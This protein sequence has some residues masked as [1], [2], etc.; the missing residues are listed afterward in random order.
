METIKIPFTGINR[1][2]DEGISTDGQCMEL[3]NAR[4]KN[5]S[6]E[7]IGNPI[8]IHELFDAKKIFYHTIAK[9]TLILLTDGRIQ[10]LNEDYTHCEWLSSDLTGKVND[11]AFIGNIACC[12]T[13]TQIQYEIFENEGYRHIGF[14]P[15]IPEIKIAQTT[16][17]ESICPDIKFLG[18]RKSSP[19]TDEEFM[20]TADYCA[21][22]YY[23][24]CIDTLNKKEYIIGP[25]LLKYAFRNSSGEYTKESPIFLVEH[26]NKIDYTFKFRG[27]TSTDYKEVVSFCQMLPYTCRDNE[28]ANATFKDYTYEFG[29]M[30]T[31][32]GFSFDDFDLSYLS[33]LV[34][35]IDVFI[36]P[37]DWFEKEEKK[38]G[39]VTYS[40]YERTQ[41]EEEQILKAYRFYKVA[42]YS[43]KGEEVW[44]LQDWSKDNISLQEQLI[45]SEIKHSFSAQ[46]NY[47]YNSRLHLANIN[48]SF[49]KG[50]DYGY[51]SLT[52]ESDTEYTLT[53][54]TTISTEQGETVVKK[55]LISKGSIIPFLT[56]PDKRAHTMTMFVQFRHSGGGIQ[57]FPK[58]VFSLKKHPY[59][60]IAYYCSPISRWGLSGEGRTD[61]DIIPKAYYISIDQEM[62][63]SMP[64]EKNTIQASKNV[65]KVSSLNNPMTFPVSQTYQ[66]STGEIIGMCSN[67]TALSQGQFGQHPLYVFS[68]DGVYAMSVGTNGIVYSTQTPVTRDVCTNPKSIK[69]IDQ[70]VVFGSQRGLMIISGSTAKSISDDMDGYLPSCVVSSPIIAKI[71][72]IGSFT[73]SSVEFNQYLGNAEVGYNYQENELIIANENYPYAY[74]FNMSSNTWSKLSCR[75]KNF[76]NKYPECYTLINTVSTSAIYDMQNNHRSVTKMLLLSKPIKMGSNSHK[77]ILQ[78]AL[79]GIVKRA[80]SDLYLRGEPVMFRGE[81]LNLFS[82]VGFYILGSND[83]E[84]F[85]LISG[86]E[87][88]VD[89]R[90][91]VTKMNK[92]K[93]Y[94]YFM[95][96]LVGGVRTDVSLNYM[97]FIASEAFANR[98]R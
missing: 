26:K 25:C 36:S 55:T 67:S 86:K 64:E 20:R 52:Q 89:I 72:N 66:P 2:I 10:V 78:T 63:T 88:I 39:S 85:A 79:R 71:A 68:T 9:K 7:P 50:Y 41:K 61:Y 93:P 58:K 4:I 70:A 17:V 97:E 15:E 24:N 83:A 49:F 27:L 31:R 33:S 38:R 1:S 23:D 11:I 8:L 56:Y 90:D 92:S 18:G 12:I 62:V 73:L 96:A 94:K 84:H 21:T 53:V 13:N 81:N 54:Y 19:L 34:V 46:T 48:Y 74:L 77:R 42:E 47:V 16:R 40:S 45:T 51:E 28:P 65:L 22:G 80:L 3:I 5:G 43:L 57:T 6:I 75:I 59:L 29:V 14:M 98:L 37:I 91:L 82:D 35:S 95:V 87:S 76:T 60:D 32:M 30:G 69:G 44:R